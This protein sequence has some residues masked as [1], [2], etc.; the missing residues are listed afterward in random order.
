MIFA[1]SAKLWGILRINF[2]KSSHRQAKF[3]KGFVKIFKNMKLHSFLISTCFANFQIRMRLCTD[4]NKGVVGA[5][6]GG[7]KG[8]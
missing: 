6:R 8:I 7:T 4:V 5:A 1:S 3:E 2:T